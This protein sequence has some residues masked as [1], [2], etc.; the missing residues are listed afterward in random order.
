[1]DGS[2]HVPVEMMQVTS[3]SEEAL[4]HFHVPNHTQTTFIRTLC[5]GS[6]VSAIHKLISLGCIAKGRQQL[7]KTSELAW[8]KVISRCQLT[9]LIYPDLASIIYVTYVQSDALF[10]CL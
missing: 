9:S 5:Q 1:M 8:D 7:H 2:N 3:A 10:P 4:W 6:I